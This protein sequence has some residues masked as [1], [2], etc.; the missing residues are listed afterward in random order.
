MVSVCVRYIC[1]SCMYS[2]IVQY[3]FLINNCLSLFVKVVSLVSFFIASGSLLNIFMDITQGLFECRLMREEGNIN[4]FLYLTDRS[5]CLSPRVVKKFVYFLT[6][7]HISRI[8]MDGKVSI[9]CFMKKGLQLSVC[10]MFTMI[11]INFFWRMKSVG[12]SVLFPH[13]IMPQLSHA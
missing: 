3:A 6:N 1:L 13:I 12:A 5:L 9:L 4:M 8:Q 7:L 11:R 10:S 2:F